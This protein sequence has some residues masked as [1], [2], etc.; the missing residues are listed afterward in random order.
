VRAWSLT[1]KFKA[2]GLYEGCS[3]SKVPWIIKL[4]EK[5]LK[6]QMHLIYSIEVSLTPSTLMHFSQLGTPLIF[7]RGRNRAFAFATILEQPFSRLHLVESATFQVLL[8]RPKR[9]EVRWDKDGSIGL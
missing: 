7:R 9:M 5:S 1:S 2:V 6:R 4:N 3:V 8:Q